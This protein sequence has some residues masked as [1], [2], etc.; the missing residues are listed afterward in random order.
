MVHHRPKFSIMY[1]T[2]TNHRLK[3]LLIST[4]P[5]HHKEYMRENLGM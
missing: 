3:V 5:S 1:I 2:P 4:E